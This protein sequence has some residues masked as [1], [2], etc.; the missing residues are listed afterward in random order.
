MNPSVIY[1]ALRDMEE[2]G[3]VSS[4]WDQ[5]QTQGPPRRI[6]C[7]TALGNEMLAISVKELKMTQDQISYF[8]NAYRQGME[9]KD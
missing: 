6:Y 3:W 4:T 1:R 7:L 5:D 9:D 2:R 8:L